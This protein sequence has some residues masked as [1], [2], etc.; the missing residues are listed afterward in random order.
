MIIVNV[1][2]PFPIRQC[3]KY[4]MSADLMPPIIGGRIVVPFRSKYI[5]GIIISICKTLE[6]DQLNLKHVKN[7][8]DTKSCY[9]DVSL[10]IL[11]WISKNYHCPIGN[12]FFSVL[13][14]ILHKDYII[15]DQI[16]YQWTITNTG[17]EKNLLTLKNKKQEFNALLILKKH[18]ILNSELKKYNLSRRILKNLQIKGL[19]QLNVLHPESFIK[20]PFFQMKKK[21]FLNKKHTIF[22][23]KILKKKKFSCWL[24]TK[25]SL[26]EKIKFYLNFVQLILNQKLQLLILVPY[27]KHIHV[28]IFFLKKFFD[29]GID[30]IHSNLTHT[31]YFKNWIKIKNRESSIIV[32]TKKSVFLPF[33]KL[34]AIL[35]FEEH[36]LNYKNTEK[37]RY[38]VK[39]I[40][41]LRAY[42]EKIPIILDSETPSLKTLHNILCRKYFN[43][44]I[45][46]YDY[47]VQFHKNIINLKREK[48]KLGLSLSLINQI[49]QHCKTGQALLIFN[50]KSFFFFVLKCSQCQWIFTCHNCKTYF[51]SNEYK[52]ILFCKFC[53]IKIKKPL[54]CYK[55]Y[56]L[57]LMV[58]N[59]SIEKLKN[60]LQDIFPDKKIFFLLNKNHIKKEMFDKTCFDFLFSTPCVI[61][62]TEEIVQNYYFPYVTLI[63][64]L[65]I[66]NY[67][68]SFEFRNMEYFLQ[69]YFN[70]IQLTKYKKNLPTIS[71]QTSY[72][73]KSILNNLSDNKYHFF[74]NEI[75]L[76]RKKFLLPPWCCQIMIYC[77]NV[78]PE[79]N[80]IFLQLIKNML[81]KKSN[82]Y[83]IILWFF[84]PNPVFSL[85]TKKIIYQ[86]LIQSLSR[87]QLNKLLNECIQTIN[88]FSISKTIKWFVDI[89]PN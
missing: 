50:K 19:C 67:F 70:L 69:L 85:K 14:N 62:S 44:N 41:I 65:C 48:V 63:S 20:K 35:I 57:S 84:G 54:F 49:I 39:D 5:V 32:G 7:L 18:S 66:D 88:L 26:Y 87:M 78:N 79:K 28:I 13:P 10:E 82:K 22:I 15:K 25:K 43:I 58:I 74:A 30:I 6:R 77:E 34:G 60:M 80:I 56:S 47:S 81:K 23:S 55:C 45:K 72:L 21:L 83:N 51:E 8:I 11:I 52:N 46:K 29:V 9:S 3:F 4:I 59:L 68:F 16:F 64:L 27:I 40:A 36:N 42:K 53:L 61:F 86:L 1:V 71:V 38:H 73:E 75:L 37:C 33:F 31:Q 17:K 89:E 76:I 24:Y 2:L 12:L